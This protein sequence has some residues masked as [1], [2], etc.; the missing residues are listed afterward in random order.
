MPKKETKKRKQI[1]SK[2]KENNVI[3]SD[4]ELT[5]DSCEETNKQKFSNELEISEIS[6]KLSEVNV[7]NTEK[8]LNNW[9]F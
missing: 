9:P 3:V 1:S 7:K 5:V 2:I 8:L 6:E 4:K